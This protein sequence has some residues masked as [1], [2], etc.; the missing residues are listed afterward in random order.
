MMKKNKNSGRGKS[1]GHQS[2]VARDQ[3]PRE[4]PQLQDQL[5]QRIILRFISTSQFSGALSI[6]YQNLLD[7]WFVAVS[8]TNAYQLFDFVR[9]KSVTLRAMGVSRPAVSGVSTGVPPCC[10]AGIEFP[11]LNSGQLGGGKQR[12]NAQLGFDTAALVTLKPDPESQQAQFQASSGS[13]CFVVRA[14]DQDG[15]ALEGVIVDIDVVYR[16]SAD[17]NPAVIG[18]ARTGLNTGQV[19][20]NGMDGLPIGST[21]FRSA[22]VPRS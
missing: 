11:G 18:T 12:T 7:A 3:I 5:T 6:S 20:F 16:N 8:A 17:V 9:L 10:T 22:F 19:F 15:S 1:K 21:A 4:L 14:S 13:T 2:Q